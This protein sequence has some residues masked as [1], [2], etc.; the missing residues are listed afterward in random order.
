M[1]G[2]H[3]RRERLSQRLL[4]AL[5]LVFWFLFSASMAAE[6]IRTN[7][8]EIYLQKLH[9][10]PIPFD[11]KQNSPLIDGQINGK[12]CVFLLDTGCTISELD[13]TAAKGLKTLKELGTTVDDPFVSQ[14]PGSSVVIMDKLALGHAE[15]LNQPAEVNKVDMDFVQIPFQ[16][17]LGFDFLSRNFALIDCAQHRLYIRAEEPSIDVSKALAETLSRSGFT[18]VPVTGA[19]CFLLPA[20]VNGHPL[21]ML[22]DTGASL[23]L[24]DQSQS[25][26]L[27]LQTVKQE[28]IGSYIPVD[29][30]FVTVGFRGVGAHKTRIV[31]L[32]SIHVAGVSWR[33][34]YFGMVDLG[35]W[36]PGAEKKEKAIHGILGPDSL[37]PEDVLID[38]ASRKLWFPRHSNGRKHGW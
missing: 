3:S 34:V 30:D 35:A 2:D 26:R 11:Y 21:D 18:N 19:V 7:S 27:G 10:D 8:L 20:H 17:V 25:K 33:T 6:Q 5:L 37:A 28:K 16:G 24:I 32:N 31:K 36:Q 9:Y 12:K 15:F 14:L 29:P 13:T 38:F 4:Y 23:S 22:V 1:S